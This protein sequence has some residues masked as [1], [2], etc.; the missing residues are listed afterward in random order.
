M[1]HRPLPVLGVQLG[2]SI[3]PADLPTLAAGCEE[4]GFRHMWLAED[5]FALGGIASASAALHAT[6][7]TIV[8]L[9]VVAAVAR[10]PAVTAMEFAHLAGAF[11][12]RFL[13]G[14][15]HGAPDWV[16]QMGLSPGS[17]LT[18]LE[19]CIT[20]IRALMAGETLTTGGRYFSFDAVRLA[21]PATEPVPLFTG[22]QGGKSLELSGRAADGTL[23]GWFSSPGYVRWARERI[24]DDAHTVVTLAVTSMGGD[25][26]AARDR[27]RPFLAR[28]LAVMGASPQVEASGIDPDALAAA[29]LPDELIDEFAVAGD[30]EQCWRTIR[31]LLDA[32][33]DAVV[34]VPSP[35]GMVPPHE[36]M[37][38]LALAA[39]TLLPMLD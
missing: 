11:P 2:A 28:Y 6:G 9:G 26:A 3:P 13:P 8:G 7:D 14:L 21:H 33:S 27:V 17:P 32:G 20:A 36:T 5:Y 16:R 22:V 38:Q 1:T 39:E 35:G 30:P 23:L 29:R 12:G 34:L 19:E 25:G 37:A 10:H 31:R 24:A 4:L 18:A 15:G